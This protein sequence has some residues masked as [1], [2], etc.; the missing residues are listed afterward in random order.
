MD[1]STA[2]AYANHEAGRSGKSTRLSREIK[3]FENGFD[4]TL[5]A[6]R[7]A[8][9]DNAIVDALSRFTIKA[10]GGRRLSRSR[11]PFQTPG[12]GCRP[13]PAH[14]CRYDAGR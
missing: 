5:V 7:I 10:T 4:C 6:L 13:L 9:N 1:K 2:V 8:G 3:E 11:A 12:N 14:G